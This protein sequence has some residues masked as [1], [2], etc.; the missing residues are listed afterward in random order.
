MAWRSAAG[1]PPLPRG[2]ECCRPDRA[3]LHSPSDGAN[4]SSRR[5][6]QA[7]GRWGVAAPANSSVPKKGGSARERK[8]AAYIAPSSLVRPASHSCVWAWSKILFLTAVVVIVL[9]TA[10]NRAASRRWKSRSPADSLMLGLSVL[11]MSG[12]LI[13]RLA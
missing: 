11:F 10:R 9:A 1:F 5:R 2:S 12:F 6:T 7:N 13:G 4:P 3:V 8:L